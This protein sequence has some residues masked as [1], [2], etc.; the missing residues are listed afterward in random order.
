[1]AKYYQSCQKLARSY[2]V[3]NISVAHRIADLRAQ[4]DDGTS[5][6]K[7]SMGILADTQTQI[8]FRQSSDQIPEATQML[9][10]TSHEAQLLPKLARGRSLWR[11]GDHVAVVQHRIGSAEWSICD[12]DQRLNL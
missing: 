2:G 3:A 11:V 12:T 10:L 6:A 8:L 7:V 4:S 1:M 9:G 5:A